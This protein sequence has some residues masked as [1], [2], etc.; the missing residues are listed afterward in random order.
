MNR[1]NTICAGI[2]SL[3]INYHAGR[4]PSLPFLTA[5]TLPYLRTLYLVYLMMDAAVEW[6]EESTCCQNTSWYGKGTFEP[7]VSTHA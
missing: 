4:P 5:N 1:G 6:A 3:P 7:S 2:I